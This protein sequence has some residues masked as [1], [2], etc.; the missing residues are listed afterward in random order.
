M[1]KLLIMKKID[2][3]IFEKIEQFQTTNEYQKISE[4]YSSLEESAQEA[5]KVILMILTI[6]L[7]LSFILIFSSLNGKASKELSQKEE[8][9]DL[10]NEL[11]KKQS[12]ITLEERKILAS[13]YVDS[14]SA[15]KNDISS[16]ISMIGID[17]SKVQISNFDT[18][19]LDGLITK[20]KADLS[21]KGFSNQELFS[22][23]NSLVAKLKIKVDEINI[24]KKESSNS[25]E[26]VM[27]IIYYSKD[28]TTDN[29]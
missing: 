19:E 10:A 27:T 6:L 11:I 15:L 18:E 23:T 5:I 28:N 12:L 26:G 9:I 22:M 21:F 24:N 20:V 13:K 4:G 25:L 29:I 16:S 3:F 14:E 7:P 2:T 1:K 17:S 8:I